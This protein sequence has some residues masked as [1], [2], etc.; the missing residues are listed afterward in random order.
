MR[1][2]AAM[3]CTGMVTERRWRT[4][5]LPRMRCAVA[6]RRETAA[7]RISRRVALKNSHAATAPARGPRA[8]SWN[9]PTAKP[10][11]SW[12]M[13]SAIPTTPATIAK[14]MSGMKP[15]SKRDGGPC[16]LSTRCWSVPVLDMAR[17][18]QV[19]EHAAAAGLAAS[20]RFGARA[21]VLVHLGVRVALA[22][23]G[24]ARG[25]AGGEHRGDDGR[26]GA[27]LSAQ[28]AEGG[29]AD[30]RTVLIGAGCTGAGGRRRLH[31]GTHR[32]SWCRPARTRRGRRARPRGS[33]CRTR[34]VDGS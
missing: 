19:F 1:A 28:H 7:G 17:S 29:G 23:A 3:A 15:R 14:T 5:P 9:T 4:E 20:A 10:L 12:R 21:A 2:T 26:V 25:D 34:L 32:H 13:S 8:P 22:R 31:A 16:G 11:R 33:R 30:I 27:A 18:S 6:C 24:S